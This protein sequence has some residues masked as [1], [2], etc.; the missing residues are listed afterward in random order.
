MELPSD[1]K[2][3][4]NKFLTVQNPKKTSL[5]SLRK[6]LEYSLSS[7]Y[8]GVSTNVEKEF[9]SS[10][11]YLQVIYVILNCFYIY[12]EYSKL[13]QSFIKECLSNLIKKDDI[14]NID[15]NEILCQILNYDNVKDES[16]ISTIE[17]Y[18]DE[19]TQAID[20]LKNLGKQFD[21]E[22]LFLSKNKTS[23][24][25]YKK[26]SEKVLFYNESKIGRNDK[27]SST[28]KR[29]RTNI[30]D[31]NLVQND[32]D[33][34]IILTDNNGKSLKKMQ[35]QKSNEEKNENALTPQKLLAIKDVNNEEKNK[36][37]LTHP[38]LLAIE[39]VNNE[40]DDNDKKENLQ[41]VP[42]KRKYTKDDDDDDYDD[43][44]TENPSKKIKL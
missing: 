41:I 11:D 27:I 40:E 31:D 6:I 44:N 1:I 35:W 14:L 4:L 13:N 8:S 24:Y 21:D 42:I 7:K 5:Y 36:N 3:I 34:I 39:Y 17:K 22:N 30:H 28:S 43:Y 16:I 2:N 23:D 20:K 9:K 19:K 12:D 26:I 32:N 29:K 15:M 25:I 10:N 18:N 38:K 33:D 37:A